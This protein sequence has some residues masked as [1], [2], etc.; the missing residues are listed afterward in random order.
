MEEDPHFLK[1]NFEIMYA[2]QWLST[3]LIK[4]G[5]RKFGLKNKGL[6]PEEIPDYQAH[7]I[8]LWETVPWFMSS[9]IN[10]ASFHPDYQN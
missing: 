3:D 5:S 4:W 9:R 7:L 1:Y 6:K 10:N 2:E 8:K